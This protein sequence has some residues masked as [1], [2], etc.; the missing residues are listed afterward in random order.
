[1][2]KN[3]L[4]FKTELIIPED[5][6]NSIN[7]ETYTINDISQIKA[8]INDSDPLI[9]LKGLVGLKKLYCL[10][11][12]KEEPIQIYND[13]NILFNILENYPE[14]FKIECFKC[15][16]FIESINYQIKEAI[17][18]EPTDKVIQIIFYILDFPKE[19]KMNLL[20]ENLDYIKFLTKNKNFVDILGVN[21]IYTKIKYLVEKEY[22]QDTNII[23]LFLE[24]LLNL[25]ITDEQ[26]IKDEQ[27]FLDLIPL[28]NDFI[29]K[30]ESVQNILH[31]SLKIIFQITNNSGNNQDN[32]DMDDKILNKLIEIKLYQKLIDK[33]DKF[34]KNEK[35]IIYCC[36][37]IIGNFA[38]MDNSYYTDI[39]IE[40]KF[41]DILKKLILKNQSFEIRREAT[42]ILSN[43]AAGTNQQLTKLYEKNFQNILF[44]IILNE[45]ESKI[46]INCLWCLYNFSN[47]NNPEYLD[48][49]V[50]KGFIDIII[51]RFKID[52]GDTLCCS[53]E[54]LNKILS[55]GKKK[56]PAHF[57][58]INAKVN[59]LNILNELKGLL[60]EFQEGIIKDKITPILNT[61]FDIVD[62]DEF[63]NHDEQVNGD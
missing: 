56:D 13:I 23:Q 6:Y 61:Y 63:L 10:E 41:L 8:N 5:Y 33:I 50:E 15:L 1:M 19:V 24:I 18:N 4:N 58:I 22:P 51:K 45:E 25:V 16:S 49:L 29:N 31:H 55:D 46:K 42:W 32:S 40:Y 36:L 59:E 37:R 57:N 39:I 48:I 43:I 60:K 17:V 35:D 34:D 30:F 9:I 62:I 21:K 7:S 20:L 26:I 2:N 53:L 38:A 11:K 3:E 47:I 27:I 12:E 54:A 52:K 28:L 14:E 44:D